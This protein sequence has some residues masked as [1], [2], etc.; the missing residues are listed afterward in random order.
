MRNFTKRVNVWVLGARCRTLP[1]AIIPVAVGAAVVLGGSSKEYDIAIATEWWSIGLV[2]LVALAL[3]I[4]VNYANDYSDGVRGV[5]QNDLRKGPVRLVGSGLAKPSQV[6]KAAFVSFFVAGCA[7]LVLAAVTSW[8]L[9]L[10]GAVCVLAAWGYTGG[11][12]PYGYIGLGEVSVFIFFGLVGT[13]GTSYVLLRQSELVVDPLAVIMS[14]P[15]GLWAAALLMANNLRD[16][17]SDEATKKYTLAVILGRRLTKYS[18]TLLLCVSYVVALAVRERYTWL[19]LV[20]APFAAHAFFVLWKAEKDDPLIDLLAATG[21][22]QV[23]SGLGLVV[24]L[25]IDG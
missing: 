12:L 16:I 9:L 17:E 3:Q 13:I 5:D 7:G 21:R 18:Y 8:W 25:A 1:A 4:G 10:V 6:K 14:V 23:F 22:V 2:L 24:G 11:P 20:G 19:V 15:V